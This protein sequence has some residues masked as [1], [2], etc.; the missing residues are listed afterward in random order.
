MNETFFSIKEYVQR[1]LY[2]PGSHGFDHTLRVTDLCHTIG[3]KEQANLD[4]LIPAALF[5]DIARPVEKKTGIPHEKEGARIAGEYLT[6]IGYNDPYIPL[7]Q[8]A[9]EAHRF[10]SDPVPVTLEAKILSDADNLDAIGAVGIA[11]TF[12]SSGERNSDIPDAV[13]HVYEKLL[14]LKDLMYTQTAEEIAMKRHNFLL[15]YMSVL[16]NEI[17]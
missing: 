17:K 11:R 2:K 4:I 15:Y 8:H 1:I 14:K 9:I 13:S 5:H 7:I 6:S 12:I 16:E 3:I 10:S